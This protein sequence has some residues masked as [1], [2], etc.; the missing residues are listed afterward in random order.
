MMSARCWLLLAT[1][2]LFALPVVSVCAAPLNDV[3]RVLERPFQAATPAGTRI[4]D[5]RA[6]FS[7]EARIASLDR[8][9]QAKG[10]LSVRFDYHR[11][12][13]DPT[14]L[15]HWEYAEPSRQEL[16]SDGTTLWVYLPEN[17]Q[18]IV[19]E[20]QR[21]AVPRESNPMA[22]LTG[23]G[24]LSRDFQ[25][26]FAVPERDAAG[27]YR[28]E[29]RPRQPSLLLERMVIAVSRTA[30]ETPARGAQVFPILST[31]VY[32]PN[33]NSTLIVFDKVH[34]NQGIPLGQFTFTPPAGVEV[35][36]PGERQ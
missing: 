14:V 27:N 36:Q 18:V 4:D 1:G 22:L 34:V 11:D 19:S 3:V 29:L 30:V 10:H 31:A 9:Q 6:D 23:L 24:N 20:L 5:Y 2:W 17:N 21:S 7:Q 35:V 8:V 16:I 13:L 33:G 32:D 12:T 15:F 25:V 28:L 26:G